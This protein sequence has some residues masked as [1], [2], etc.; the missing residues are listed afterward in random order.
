[1]QKTYWWRVIIFFLGI[2]LIGIS[3]ILRN[4]IQF[5]FCDSPYTFGEYQGCFDK[6]SHSIGKPL[7]F[8][9]LSILVVSSFLF[10][11]RDR[12][13]MKWL[14]FAAVWF[15]LTAIFVYLAPEY[16]GGWMSFGPTKEL[17]S[18]WM[19]ILFVILS[20]IKLAWDSWKLKHGRG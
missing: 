4:Q 18:I 20:A 16:T 9:S 5:G 11:V 15:A 3:Y 19:G 1:M 8:F 6:T 14:R 2:L 10:F 17:V 12:V 13:F 7:L